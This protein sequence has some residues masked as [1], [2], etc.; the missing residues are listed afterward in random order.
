M[1][2][3]VPRERKRA[4]TD[5]TRTL[6]T[7]TTYRFGAIVDPGEKPGQLT[8]IKPGFLSVGDDGIIL[9]VS[10]TAPL[11]DTYENLGER[12]ILIPGFVDTHV[13]A[14]QYTYT[15]TGTELPLMTWL[16]RYAFPAERRL[17]NDLGLSRKVYDE[18]VTKMLKSGTTTALYFGVVG[19]ESCKELVNSCVE[20]GQRAF[21]GKVCMDRLCPDDYRDKSVQDALFQTEAFVKYV[22]E[23]KSNASGRI[24]PVVTPRFVPCCS[25]SL[26][27]GLGELAQRLRCAVQSHAVESYDCLDTVESLHPGKDEVTLLEDAG[28]LSRDLPAVVMA[29]CV[30]IN[31]EQTRRFVRTGTSIAHCPLSNTYFAGG[32]LRTCALM[33]RGLKIGLGTDVAGGYSWRMA[34]SVRHAVT[35]HLTVASADRVSKGGRCDSVAPGTGERCERNDF[36]WKHAFWLATVGGARCLGLEGKIGRLLPGFAFDAALIQGGQSKILDWTSKDAYLLHFEKWLMNGDDREISE[37]W[38][39][40]KRVFAMK[41][42]I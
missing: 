6:K 18:L 23:L 19:V 24:K 37:V 33:K 3:S 28:L 32:C 14:A 42:G 25:P 17:T 22:R 35:T 39:A 31:E 27:S 26:L 16:K 30:H 20:L 29:H 5:E 1:D 7:R 11:N 38:V 36:S 40:G 21:V 34:S 8:L 9:S 15:G 12:T 4:R 41:R 13:H 10:Q 2:A